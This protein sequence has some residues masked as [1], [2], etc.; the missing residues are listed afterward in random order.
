[1]CHQS[2]GLIA[3][4]SEQQGIPTVCLSSALSITQS[5]KAPRAVYIDYPLGHTSGKPHNP[6]DQEFIIRSALSAITDITEPG[7]IIDLGRRWSDSDEWKD[8]VMRP[9]NNRS[10]KKDSDDRIERF[11]TPQYQTSE[12]AK[13]ADAHCPTCIFTENTL[14]EA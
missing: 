8:A 13:V 5:V 4:R 7:S 12:D 6:D 11:S 10:K 14:S 9:S 3:K 1:M 2:V